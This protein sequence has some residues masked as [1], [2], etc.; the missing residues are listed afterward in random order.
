MS[1]PTLHILTIHIT[2]TN[3]K[4]LNFYYHKIVMHTLP[5]RVL[6]IHKK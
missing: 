4:L 6:L 1:Q 3:V 5:L 2:I